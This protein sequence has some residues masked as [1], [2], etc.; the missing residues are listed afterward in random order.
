MAGDVGNQNT[1]LTGIDEEK[2]VEI[3]SYRGHRMVGGRDDEIGDLRIPGRKDRSLN[4]S[5]NGQL[6]FNRK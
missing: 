4:F 1:C 6:I 3:A 5:S 2:I